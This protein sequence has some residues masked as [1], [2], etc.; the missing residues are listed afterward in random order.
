MFKHSRFAI[1]LLMILLLFPY[2]AI[3]QSSIEIGDTIEESPEDENL[4]YTLPLTTGDSIVIDL[5][6]EAFSSLIILR[7]PEGNIVA[8]DEDSGDDFD[9]SRII[10]IV[11]TDGDYEISVEASFGN[12]DGDFSLSVNAVEITLLE[13]D[14]NMDV[15]AA[16]QTRM[17]FMFEGAEGDVINLFGETNSDDDNLSLEIR[18][19]DGIL[20]ARDDNGGADLNPYIRRYEL[21]EDGQY[22]I[23]AEVSSDD[24][25]Q[26]DFEIEL[27]QTEKLLF[28]EEEIEFELG[29]DFDYEVF[30][31]DADS[32]E[33]YNLVLKSEDE[34]AEALL[35]ILPS[36]DNFADKRFNVSEFVEISYIFE[37]A[38]SGE[39][40]VIVSDRTFDGDQDYTISLVLLEE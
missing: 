20:M 3:A 11:P 9:D 15:E 17:Y 30:T 35:E 31:F 40:R 36:G 1:A 25:F 18:N 16:G 37:A 39:T 8:Q 32:G 34:E 29:D 13:Y 4:S 21:P 5:V 23:F 26:G 10:Y 19:S 2:I 14:S 7:D 24:G 28:D 12:P 22:R 27:E 6:T 33:L 38:N